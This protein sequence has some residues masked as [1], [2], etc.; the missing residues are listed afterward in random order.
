MRENKTPPACVQ[1]LRTVRQIAPKSCIIK[2]TAANKAPAS[3]PDP[4][5]PAQCRSPATHTTTAAANMIT[6]MR[7]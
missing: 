5:W 7:R 2:T 6:E 3:Q 1:P 4:A